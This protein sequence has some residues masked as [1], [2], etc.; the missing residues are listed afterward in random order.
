MP[1]KTN[2]PYDGGLT[3]AMQC[4]DLD[5]AIRWYQDVLGFELIYRMDEMAWAEMRTPV[6]RVQVGL[7]QVEDP[8]TR[9]GATL[10]WGTTDID[11]LRRDLEN[12]DVEFDGATQEIPNMVKLATFFDPDGNRHMLYQ[13]LADLGGDR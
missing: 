6:D 2:L 4:A 11:V 13:E 8:Q 3:C 7:G 10:T 1:L 5:A 9:G 12:K